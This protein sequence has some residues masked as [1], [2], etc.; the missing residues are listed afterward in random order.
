MSGVPDGLKQA[1]ALY[2]R[3]DFA[4]AR[5]AAEAT[6]RQYP[7]HPVLLQLL[8]VIYGQS[9]ETEK[10][11]AMLTRALK[12]TPSHVQTR[13]NLAKALIDAGDPARAEAV[14]DP[15]AVPGTMTAELWRLRGDALKAAGKLQ[16]A[17]VAYESAVAAK[18]DYVDAWNNLGNTRRS[19]GDREG[20]IAAL[21]EALL[22]RPDLPLAHL[23]FAKALN[24]A[25]RTQ[26]AVA[27]LKAG[28]RLAPNDVPMLIDL[29]NDYSRLN[30]SNEALE[31]LDRAAVLKPGDADIHLAIGQA[32]AKLHHIE[33]ASAAFRRTIALRPGDSISY[34]NFGTM[35]EKSNRLSDV[36]A[37]LAEAEAS[38]VS[39]D[40]MAILHAS[41]LR[42]EGKL[43][44]ALALA[45]AAATSVPGIDTAR[46]QL[47]GELADRLGQFDLA[48]ASF[49]EMN[50]LMAAEPVAAD[51]SGALFRKRI[52]QQQEF[53]TPAWVRSWR[54]VKLDTSR[55]PPVFLVGFPRSGTTLLD[56]VL[57]GHPDL[58][59]LEEEPVMQ[60]V[61]EDIGEIALVGDLDTLA[62]NRLRALYF[63]TLDSISTPRPGQMVIDKLPMHI[64]ST[65]LIR[66][67]FPDAK[68]IFAERHPC[69]AVLS[70]FM[71]NFVLNHAMASFL[72]LGESAALYDR[73][74]GYWLQCKAVFDLPVQNVRYEAMVEDMEAEVRPLIDFLGLPWRDAVLDNQKT[75]RLRGSIKTPSYAQVTEKIYT[76]SS[77]RWT[78]YR[79]YME[80]VLP[81]LAPWCERF[82]YSLD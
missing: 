82:G 3:K 28:L 70:C 51:Y 10:S 23:N 29:G 56:T 21:E 58:H 77:G 80:P 55:P 53:T 69:D 5:A 30:R 50:R 60:R 73:L 75:A 24:A 25:A 42:R 63:K 19:A 57:M 68:F 61:R 35:L 40:E 74:I 43:P 37:L 39:T 1:A 31:Y 72:D 11:V 46:A 13:L 16:E 4:G 20:A 62:V 78:R 6:L 15:A 45:Q 8:G 59:V 32:H 65:P 79:K 17:I 18:P 12:L 26:D 47:I 9:G 34:L 14:S 52:E 44:E 64:V 2:Q 33:E 54:P 7:D 49:T 48:I 71:Q 38:G 27:I 81:I 67:I 36:A 66:R 76:R 22:L 41:L